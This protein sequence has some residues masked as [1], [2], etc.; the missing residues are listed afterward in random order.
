ML[1]ARL[2]HRFPRL[3]HR[4]QRLCHRFPRLYHRFP[5]LCLQ[6]PCLC[7]RF[8]HRCR[9]VPFSLQDPSNVAAVGVHRALSSSL[10]A[11]TQAA[12]PHRK[13]LAAS[14]S[15]THAA[16]YL[17]VHGGFKSQLFVHGLCCEAYCSFMAAYC[18]TLQPMLSH[19]RHDC[20]HMSVH[21]AVAED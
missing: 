12:C 13:F 2:C 1:L 7:H 4:F 18:R 19:T 20:L 16:Q 8:P 5:R 6:A 14:V 11:T 3:C 17:H 21:G 15:P 9:Q 10:E